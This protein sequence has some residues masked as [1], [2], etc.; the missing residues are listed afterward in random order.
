M[1]RIDEFHAGAG[2]R[3][4]LTPNCSISW[5]QLLVFYILTCA[6]AIV[7]GLLFSLQGQWL[8]LPF[9]GLEMLVLGSALH[10]TSRKVN[11]REVITVNVDRVRIEKGNCRPE[12][13]WV[14]K[15][16]WVRLL[17]EIGGEN[18]SQRKLALGSHGSYVEVGNFLSNIEKE[19]LAFRLKGCIISR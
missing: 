10:I 8:I 3:L 5:R 11:R 9:S 19:E 14:F 7:I 12:E 1:I 2:H 15:R 13:Q 4:I 6:L 17:D 16:C 18:R